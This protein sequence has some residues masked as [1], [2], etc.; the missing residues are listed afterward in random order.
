MTEGFP[1]VLQLCNKNVWSMLGYKVPEAAFC[2]F[3]DV[4]FL[5]WTAAKPPF[6]GFPFSETCAT[7]AW[8]LVTFVLPEWLIPIYKARYK[9]HQTKPHKQPGNHC[10]ESAATAALTLYCMTESSLLVMIWRYIR[11]IENGPWKAQREGKLLA[12]LWWYSVKKSDFHICLCGWNNKQ[13]GSFSTVNWNKRNETK[14]VFNL[15]GLKNVKLGAI[16]GM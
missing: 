12:S 4:F 6:V 7:S 10:L 9:A 15:E 11:L 14:D 1:T 2:Q 8:G 3:V 13:G 5:C 16:N